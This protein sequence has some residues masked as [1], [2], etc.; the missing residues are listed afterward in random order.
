MNTIEYKE[1]INAFLIEDLN[2][3]KT[4]K[5]SGKSSFSKAVVYE[6]LKTPEGKTLFSRMNWN[7]TLIGGT[8]E[9]ACEMWGFDNNR[10]GRISIRE[11]DDEMNSLL[12]STPLNVREIF[13]CLF[14]I[15]G[16]SL[17]TVAP[18]V[19]SGKG[20]DF[21]KVIPMRMIPVAEDTGA[22]FAKYEMRSI[23]NG[24]SKYYVKRPTSI[25]LRNMTIDGNILTNYPDTSHT[26]PE[27]VITAVEMIVDLDNDDMREYF[28]LVEGDVSSRRFSA[29]S[30]VRGDKVEVS[31]GGTR[32]EHR[33]VICT[34]RV[35]GKDRNLE[36]YNTG[37]YIIITY[38]G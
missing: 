28:A 34:Q 16:A 2:T 4:M 12:P 29:I 15:D 20:Y 13:G 5:A 22:L 21:S 7:N 9:T 8:Q 14:S 32:T 6:E 35:N 3:V 11:F 26:T 24:Y 38:Y 27:D 25:T 33:N 18:V 17:G 30:L 1:D 36:K 23:E 37:R 31:Y 19:R 10:T